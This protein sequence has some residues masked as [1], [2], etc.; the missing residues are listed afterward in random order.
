M[1]TESVFK[2]LSIAI[3]IALIFVGVSGA[4][5]E[6]LLKLQNI[7]LRIQLEA[8]EL[9]LKSSIETKGSSLQEVGLSVVS[10]DYDNIFFV[11]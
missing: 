1:I 8:Q 4:N 5:N 2:M 10:C 6:V 3:F 11:K 7:A 9:Y